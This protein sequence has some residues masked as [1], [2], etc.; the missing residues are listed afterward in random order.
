MKLN[1]FI[2]SSQ[3]DEGL[4]S[5]F[6]KGV[7]I[8]T[9]LTG[10]E[11]INK[12][13]VQDFVSRTRNKLN[14][15]PNLTSDQLPEILS[16]ITTSEL[17]NSNFT[18]NQAG[19]TS[20]KKA[21][22]TVQKNY[23]DPNK[24]LQALTLLGNQVYALQKASPVTPTALATPVTPTALATPVTP[25]APATPVTPT[26]PAT[27]VTPTAPATPVT[28]TAGSLSGWKA[29]ATSMSQNP[30][31]VRKTKL[32]TNAATAQANMNRPVVAPA[33]VRA[34]PAERAAALAAARAKRTVTPE[35]K[36]KI[37][38]KWGEE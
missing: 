10:T 38:K 23:S 17:K 34:T 9:T 12:K 22:D 14:R 21:I 30:E 28:P 5:S 4:L 15:M 31:Q 7:G 18:T 33:N 11:S 1:E 29:G 3:I 6:A 35:S 25:T 8:P 2:K 24:Y 19:Q 27:P 37:V 36:Q 26:A 13:F 16:A 32:A 20:I